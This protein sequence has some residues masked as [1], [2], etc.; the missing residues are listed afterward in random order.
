MI[1]SVAASHAQGKSEPDSIF[2]VSAA[3]NE[4][5]KS[6]GKENIVN[7]SIGAFLDAKGQLITLPTVERTIHSLDFKDTANYAPISVFLIL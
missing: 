7:A 5:A 1:K 6:V 3:A 4:K 2:A